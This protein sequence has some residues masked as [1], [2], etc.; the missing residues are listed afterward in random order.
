MISPWWWL[1]AAIL[2]AALEMLTTTFYLIWPA[3]AALVTALA[4]WLLPEM[5]LLAQLALFAV[6]TIFFTLSGRKLVG[7]MGNNAPNSLNK[8]AEQLVGREAVVEEFE[9]HEGK[10]MIDGIP[11]P[12]RLDGSKTPAPGDRMKVVAADGI[13]VWVKPL[14]DGS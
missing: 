8:R 1:A 11:W 9:F 7:S 6:L 3:A 13:V 10:V 5:S 2:M 12:A 4:L 14:A